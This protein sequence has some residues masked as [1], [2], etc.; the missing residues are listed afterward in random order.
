MELKD[1]IGILEQKILD[2]K[3][4]DADQSE[5]DKVQARIDELK[6]QDEAVQQEKEQRVQA[7]EEKVQS[8]TLPYDFDA[9]F[10]DPRANEMITEL[11]QSFQRQAYADHNAEV[12]Q[13]STTY[14]DQLRSAEDREVQI[15]RQNAE[16]QKQLEEDSAKLAFSM[17]T[18]GELIKQ[19]DQISAEKAEFEQKLANA[20]AE[21]DDANREIER[22]NSHI[23]DLRKDAAVGAKNGYKVQDI[24]TSSRLD[25]LVKESAAAKAARALER[26]NQSNPE[27]AAPK[28]EVPMAP[29]T[30]P[31]TESADDTVHNDNPETLAPEVQ[32]PVIEVPQ[33][34]VPDNIPA[35]G[36]A[37]E[38]QGVQ[39][40][41]ATLEE[42]IAALEV[43]VFGQVRKAS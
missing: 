5:I 41:G 36:M 7:Q 38:E 20:T 37:D 4:E 16:I 17:Q 39:Q 1:Q 14:R 12:E 40:T 18:N 30:F 22:L 21:L 15:K 26:W 11:I 34:Q 9:I 43:A 8:L 28:L 29:A 6:S 35:D 31:A 25:E 27:L 3:E 33:F 24:S 32:P 2:L 10:D 19:R 23:D 13:I 42:R